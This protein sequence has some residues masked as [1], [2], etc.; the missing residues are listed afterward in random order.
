MARQ[1]GRQTKNSFIDDFFRVPYLEFCNY[2]ILN[3]I[4]GFGNA[5]TILRRCFS[6]C[7]IFLGYFL[8]AA[9]LG[10][11]ENGARA[12]GSEYVNRNNEVAIF[13]HL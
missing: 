8:L 1:V 2:I 9:I 13:T 3:A 10:A 4:F 7:K 5:K 12:N 6:S 11:Q